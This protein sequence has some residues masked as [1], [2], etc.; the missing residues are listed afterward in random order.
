MLVIDEVNDLHR[1]SIRDIAGN[2]LPIYA[3]STGKAYLAHLSKEEQEVL[4]NQPLEAFTEATVRSAAE[5]R[6]ELVTIQQQGYACA[7]EELEK[8]LVAIGVPIFNGHGE[9]CASIC[10]AGPSVRMMAERLPDFIEHL[11][12]CGREISAQNGWRQL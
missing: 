1:L 4:L 5:L 9:V 6:K 7:N 8:G 12:A 2:H 11:K 10:L 3:T